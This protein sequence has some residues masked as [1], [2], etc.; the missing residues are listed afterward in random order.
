MKTYECKKCNHKWIPRKERPESCPR[1]KSF[2]WDIE[3]GGI[4]QICKRHF[5][6]LHKHHIDKNH[7]NN[8]KKNTILICED[9]HS[10]IHTPEITK[11]IS[12]HHRRI[13]DYNSPEIISKINKLRKKL[14]AKREIKSKEN[15]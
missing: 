1:C 15:K 6:K 9:C 2:L 3:R 7:K 11:K 13:R 10:K 4:C 5:L 8:N 12:N 14:N